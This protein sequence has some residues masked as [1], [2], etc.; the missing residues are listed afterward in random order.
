MGWED[1]VGKDLRR[2]YRRRL[3]G[4]SEAWEGAKIEAL[5]RLR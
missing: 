2:V 4:C 3:K 1:A 5:N